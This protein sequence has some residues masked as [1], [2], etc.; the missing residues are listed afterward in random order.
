MDEHCLIGQKRN[1][2][3][4]LLHPQSDGDFLLPSLIHWACNFFIIPP[5]GKGTGD[6]ALGLTRYIH[7]FR[8]KQDTGAK[9]HT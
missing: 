4:P 9:E 2:Q 8:D 6:T 5:G 3:S 7:C 1:F